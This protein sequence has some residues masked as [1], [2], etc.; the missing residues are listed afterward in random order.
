MKGT[1]TFSLPGAKYEYEVTLESVENDCFIVRAVAM[2]THTP[3][4]KVRY[5]LTGPAI[6]YRDDS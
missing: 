6:E 2:D 3:S 1:L 5:A 4:G